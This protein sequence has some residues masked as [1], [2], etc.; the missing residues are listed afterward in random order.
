MRVTR[1]LG[2]NSDFAYFGGIGPVF[3]RSSY[4]HSKKKNKYRSVLLKRTSSA[5]YPIILSPIRGGRY[6]GI[7]DTGLKG[8]FM[9]IEA[10]Y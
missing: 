2:G 1:D 10:F 5:S 6:R 9:G 7:Y 8:A 3:E 4:S